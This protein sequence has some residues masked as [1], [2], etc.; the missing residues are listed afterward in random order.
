MA[1][2][3]WAFSNVLPPP[4]FGGFQHGAAVGTHHQKVM[5]LGYPALSLQCVPNRTTSNPEVPTLPLLGEM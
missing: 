3:R 5:S 2:F 4:H 1:E